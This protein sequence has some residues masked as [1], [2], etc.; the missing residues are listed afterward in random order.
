MVGTSETLCFV[1]G[2][3]ERLLLASVKKCKQSLGLRIASKKDTGEQSPP[4]RKWLS[5]KK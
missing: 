4:T 5:H 3:I 1:I 2:H